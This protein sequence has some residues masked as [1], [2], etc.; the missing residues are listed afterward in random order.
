MKVRICVIGNGSFANRVHYPAL[1]SFEDVEIVGICAFHEERLKKT[2]LQFNIPEQNIYVSKSPADYQ[3]M[4]TNA[5]ARRRLC[6]W[7]TWRDA[8]HLDLV[9]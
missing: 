7:P 6:D 8:G 4:L 2:A 1:A 3:R 5:P 9:P